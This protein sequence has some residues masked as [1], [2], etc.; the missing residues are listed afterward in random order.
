[1]ATLP[2]IDTAGISG[3]TFYNV[4]DEQ[5]V[6]DSDFDPMDFSDWSELSNLQIYDNGIDAQIPITILS[7]EGESTVQE[8]S[9]LR[10]RCKNDGWL[11]IW[12]PIDENY[13]GTNIFIDGTGAD[14]RGAYNFYGLF[15]GDSNAWISKM[16]SALSHAGYGVSPTPGSTVLGHYDFM[17]PDAS[18]ITLIIANEQVTQSFTSS[19][20]RKFHYAAILNKGSVVDSSDVKVA[21]SNTAFQGQD[22]SFTSIPGSSAFDML[23]QVSQGWNWENDITPGETYETA[24]TSQP[25]KVDGLQNTNIVS[26]WS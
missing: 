14:L 26:A 6:S 9:T 15:C 20:D 24:Y 18:N 19:V 13:F 7:G 4:K 23:N 25:D 21:T 22:G 11:I 8:E 5:G 10:F 16:E 17:A 12:M 3:I 2:D 1:M